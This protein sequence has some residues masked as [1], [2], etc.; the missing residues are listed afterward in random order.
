MEIIIHHNNNYHEEAKVRQDGNY[1][2]TDQNHKAINL[3]VELER[4]RAA[5]N[6]LR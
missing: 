2:R 6:T 5:I 1:K 3:L 4:F